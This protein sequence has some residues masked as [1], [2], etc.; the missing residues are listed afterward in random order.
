ME[1]NELKNIDNV[2]KIAL[3]IANDVQKEMDKIKNVNKENFINGFYN[4]FLDFLKNEY[5]KFDGRICRRRFLMITLYSIIIGMAISLVT[6]ILPFL[7]FLGTFYI[8][9]LAVPSLGLY[10]RRLH[11]IDFPWWFV[12]LAFVPI[13][14]FIALVFFI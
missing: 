13:V 8:L 14:G 12:L 4:C 2:K 11:D 5:F 6:T 9:A 1:I 3:N 10:V 7:E